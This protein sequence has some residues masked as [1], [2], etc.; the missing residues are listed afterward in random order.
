MRNHEASL[1]RLYHYF[2]ADAKS[3]GFFGFGWR[4][5]RS[6]GLHTDAFSLLVVLYHSRPIGAEIAYLRP[7]RRLL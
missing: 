5:I 6:K 2:S 4:F 7:W 1:Q 3:G